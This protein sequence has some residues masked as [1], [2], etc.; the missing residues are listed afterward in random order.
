[1]QTGRLCIFASAK[2]IIFYLIAIMDRFIVYYGFIENVLLIVFTL[3]FFCQHKKHIVIPLSSKH[4]HL[5][6]LTGR[7]GILLLPKI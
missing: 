6:M 3:C 7:R 5:T 2:D 4:A 1:M